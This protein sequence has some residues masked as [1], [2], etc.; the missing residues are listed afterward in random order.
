MR[1]PV[2]RNTNTTSVSGAEDTLRSNLVSKPLQAL[3]T[4]GGRAPVR[5]RMLEG[6]GTAH[7][8]GA[9]DTGP[10]RRPSAPSCSRGETPQLWLF[11]VGEGYTHLRDER[12]QLSGR[13]RHLLCNSPKSSPSSSEGSTWLGAER[14][15]LWPEP[16]G[17]GE[18]LWG[19]FRLLCS[20]GS[21]STT[22][23]TQ[24]LDEDEAAWG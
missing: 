12:L 19:S 23:C 16:R 20:A 2:E 4:T 10:W 14:K 5:S 8:C 18:G 7:M 22:L 6:M 21:P 17:E 24:A 3:S 9:S 1:P 11:Q 13:D 15:L